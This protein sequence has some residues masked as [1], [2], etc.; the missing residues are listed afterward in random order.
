[1]HLRR[2]SLVTAIAAAAVAI[3]AAFPATANPRVEQATTPAATSSA[4]ASVVRGTLTLDCTHLSS[5]ARAYAVAHN[6]CPSKKGSAPANT[7]YGNCGSSWIY[8]FPWGYAGEADVYYGFSSSKGTVVYRYLHVYWDSSNGLDGGWA[9]YG[10]MFSSRYSSTRNVNPGRGWMYA[11]L[12][13]WV[14]LWWGGKC[15]LLVPWDEDYV[16]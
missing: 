13:G 15:Y 11:S 3:A 1:M 9:N 10:Y 7:V 6:Y 16:A 5:K 8:I 14:N 12:S 2:A 4:P